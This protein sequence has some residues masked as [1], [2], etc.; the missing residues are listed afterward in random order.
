M[1]NLSVSIACPSGGGELRPGETAVFPPVSHLPPLAS[2]PR[3]PIIPALCISKFT[4]A[5]RCA[6]ASHTPA[7]GMIGTWYA[8]AQILAWCARNAADV[9]CC[10]A[11]NSTNA[12]KPSSNTRP[13]TNDHRTWHSLC[14][15]RFPPLSLRPFGVVYS[16]AILAASPR[17]V[18]MS[19]CPIG[20]I[21]AGHGAASYF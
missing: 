14:D 18:P 4:W 21:A 2:Q 7:G 11:G 10:H 3:W 8:S 19:D 20:G 6:C 13:K 12:S 1:A 9:C 16:L 15:G 17:Y 5:T